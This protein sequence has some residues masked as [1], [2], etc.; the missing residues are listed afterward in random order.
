MPSRFTDKLY[1]K[2]YGSVITENTPFLCAPRI[3][4]KTRYYHYIH[5]V[6]LKQAQIKSYSNLFQPIS[7]CF[8]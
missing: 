8:E 7:F 2:Y 5:I 6:I 1:H 4:L 3:V